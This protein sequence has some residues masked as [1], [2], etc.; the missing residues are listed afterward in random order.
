MSKPCTSSSASSSPVPV[1]TSTVTPGYHGNGSAASLPFVVP[2]N[3][4]TFER[5]ASTC[6][7][8]GRAER[9][10]ISR[11]FST[12]MS[13]SSSSAAGPP[14]SVPCEPFGP[15]GEVRGHLLRAS[16][17]DP[18]RAASDRPRRH[19]VGESPARAFDRFG[20]GREGDPQLGDLGRRHASTFACQAASSSR[21]RSGARPTGSASPARARDPTPSSRGASPAVAASAARRRAPSTDRSD[22]G[23]GTAPPPS[24]APARPRGRRVRAGR[25]RGR[26]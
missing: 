18:S 17:P 13:T 20:G 16:T 14:D 15:G 19:E 25:T 2:T 1:A 6:C 22:G 12:A 4:A 9:A 7:S 10:R 3:D 21:S 11:S 24:T 8:K 26:R 23:R 5:S